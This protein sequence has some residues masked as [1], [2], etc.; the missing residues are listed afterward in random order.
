MDETKIRRRSGDR[1]DGRL[2]RSLPGFGN[3]IPFIMKDRN[4]ALVQYEESFEISVVDKWLRA[5]RVNGYKGMGFLH[6]MIAAYI[7]CV[8]MFPGINRFIAGRRIFARYGI[9]VVM[10]VKKELSLNA[11]ETTI[12]VHFQP[13]DTIYDVYRKMNEQIAEIKANE[14]DNGTEDFANAITRLPRFLLSFAIW[15]LK[16]MD[17]FGILPDAWTEIS[18]FH[19]SMIITDMGSLRMGPVYHPIYNFGTLPAFI[20]IGSKYHKYEV[21]KNAQVEDRKYIDAKYVIDERICDGHYYATFF[22]AMRYLAKHPEV[23]ETPP[24]KVNRDIL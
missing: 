16:G 7:R 11:E 5:Q 3:F 23:L 10:T 2:I 9:D 6:F 8:A 19:G 20:A 1:K 17:F 22:Q 14:D 21:N 15:V 24:S 12:K 18:P 4:D 13:T